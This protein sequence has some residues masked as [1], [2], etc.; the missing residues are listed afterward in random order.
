MSGK[1]SLESD[2]QGTSNQSIDFE[3]VRGLLVHR[4]P[5]LMIDKVVSFDPGKE[6]SAIKNVTG[7]E[8]H[9]LG[10]F[11]TTAIMPG[12]LVIEAM[13]QAMALLC[14]LSRGAD[15]LQNSRVLQSWY[16]AK[17][18][19]R[20]YHPVVPGDQLCLEA[21]LIRALDC[22][23]IATVVARTHEM[24]AKGELTLAGKGEY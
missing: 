19:A 10:H 8:I 15:L 5:F 4:F 18:E 1:L 14:I 17:V 2:D 3:T 24:V 21:R 13:A 23:A 11:P 20:F 12:V 22:G 16:L 7:N 6:I 9:F